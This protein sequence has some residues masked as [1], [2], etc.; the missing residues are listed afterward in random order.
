M[1]WFRFLMLSSQF[2]P[3][4]DATV[5]TE[6]LGVIFVNIFS[7]NDLVPNQLTSRT[8]LLA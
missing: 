7:V 8:A 5:V 3:A 1:N 4:R 2:A 6:P